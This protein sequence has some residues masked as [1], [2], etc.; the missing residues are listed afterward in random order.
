MKSYTKRLAVLLALVLAAVLGSAPAF[1]ADPT[2]D[3]IYQAQRAGDSAKARQ[4]M[5]E[6]LRHHPDSAKAHYVDAELRAESGDAA[7]AGEALATAQ[8]LAPGLPFANQGEVLRLQSRIS[9]GPG[10]ADVPSPRARATAPAAAVGPSGLSASTIVFA[11]AALALFVWV[12]MRFVRKAAVENSARGPG[13]PSYAPAPY[14]PPQGPQGY[15]PVGPQYAPQSGGG[16]GGRVAGGLATGLAVGAGVMAA[17]AIGSRMFGH[18]ANNP[19]LGDHA[20]GGGLD[21]S[22]VYQPAND[23]GISDASSWDDAGSSGSDS[24]S[25]DWDT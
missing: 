19:A 9:I 23:F 7:R 1:A 3:Q 16:L 2:I 4:M 11:L 15:G 25:S 17:E 13:G 6:V 8:R 20:G 10:A 21:H 12:V 22:P 14:G 24:G 5:D 18:D